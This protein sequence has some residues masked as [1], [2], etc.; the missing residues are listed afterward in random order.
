MGAVSV[1]VVLGTQPGFIE[2]HGHLIA[3]LSEKEVQELCD[4]WQPEPLGAPLTEFQRLAGHRDILAAAHATIRR[5][6]VGSCGPR[7]ILRNIRCTF[8]T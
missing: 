3:P 5:F 4:E 8:R 2:H 1:L 7:V 6:G